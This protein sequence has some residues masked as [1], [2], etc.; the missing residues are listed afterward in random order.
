MKK[1]FISYKQTWIFEEELNDTLGFL[2]EKIESLGYKTMI[3]YFDDN[4][5]LQAD[6]LDKNFLENIKS[7]DIFISFLNYKKKSEWQ[8]MELWMAYALWEEIILLV[9]R[10][11]KDNYYLAYWT[12]DK[13]FEFDKLQDLNFKKIF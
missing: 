9:N 6:I 5:D 7:C 4:S 2:R 8:L 10:E 3:Y 13:I 1:I 12:T 11:V